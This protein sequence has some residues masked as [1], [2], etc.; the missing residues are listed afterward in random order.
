[1]KMKKTI[2]FLVLFC[3]IAFAQQKGTFTDSRNGK[4]YKTVKIGDQ[5]W[6]AENLNY[7]TDSSVC[8]GSDSD[9]CDKYG[10][11][12]NWETAKKV[13]PSGWYLPNY[14]EWNTLMTVAGG[15]E[16]AA[17]KLKAKSGWNNGGNG[18]DDFGFSALPGGKCCSFDGNFEDIGNSGN[19]WSASATESNADD[20]YYWHIYYKYNFV[21]WLGNPKL[22]L[23]SVRCL[24]GSN[25][26]HS[27]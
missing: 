1:M 13:C 3:V 17:T 21:F 8:Y 5:T 9:N 23:Y 20:A 27:P 6:M 22:D 25:M 15:V 10:R 4:K 14:D 16:N 11:L 26:K 19:W 24:Q 18:T 7:E 12:Y 2:M